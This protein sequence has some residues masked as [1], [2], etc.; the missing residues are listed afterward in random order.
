MRS[1]IVRA[2][3]ATSNGLNGGANAEPPPRRALLPHR[4]RMPSQA[5]PD[6]GDPGLAFLASPRS[7]GRPSADTLACSCFLEVVTEPL[8]GLDARRAAVRRTAGV[9][10]EVYWRTRGVLGRL[11]C[12]ERQRRHPDIELSLDDP[13]SERLAQFRSVRAHWPPPRQPR[14][15]RGRCRVRGRRVPETTGRKSRGRP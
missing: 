15:D 13:L 1:L 12:R 9:C 5:P 14:L 4:L 2:D 11:A 8:S 6:R 7:Q 3:D 10:L